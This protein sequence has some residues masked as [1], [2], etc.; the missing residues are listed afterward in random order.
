MGK[1]TR[2]EPGTFSWAELATNDPKGAKDFYTALFGWEP[3]DVPIDAT[4]TYTMLNLDG[5]A[6]AALYQQPE[7]QSSAGIPPNWL[8]YVTVD[9]ADEVARRA[10][11]LGGA[12]V[13]EPFDVLESGRMSLIQDPAGA[14]L[15]LWE[16]RAHIGAARVNDPGCLCWNDL[17]TPDPAAAER[18]YEGLLGWEIE[19]LEGAG[20]YRVVEN[21]GQSNGG[22]M[23]ASLAGGGPPHW[24]VYFNAGHLAQALAR[25][26][27]GGGRVIAGPREV[28]AGRF[29][30]AQDPQ[31]AAFGLFEGAVD[32]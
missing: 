2:Y 16:P 13:A 20:G 19:E 14:M 30:V 11:Q 9:S 5:D 25:I 4:A 23:P 24:L 12:V 18:F 21:A 28:P 8:S 31:G 17:I 3:E 27:D 10:P 6:V 32:D 26:E 1:R 7:E 22:M 15:A 29:A